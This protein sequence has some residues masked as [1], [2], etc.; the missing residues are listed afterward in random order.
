MWPMRPLFVAAFLMFLIAAPAGG[1]ASEA[2]RYDSWRQTSQGWQRCEDFL[3][4]PIEYR[5]P[6]L[7]PAVVGSLEVLLSVTALLALGGEQ[8]AQ[9]GSRSRRGGKRTEFGGEQPLTALAEA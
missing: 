9:R 8:S 3:A 5:R 6:S 7:H 2:A 1:G 4:P